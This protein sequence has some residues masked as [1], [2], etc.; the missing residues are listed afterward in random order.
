[1]SPHT[2]YL[3]RGFTIHYIYMFVITLTNEK[4]RYTTQPS[5]ELKIP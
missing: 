2:E 1:M 4:F 5:V 3:I